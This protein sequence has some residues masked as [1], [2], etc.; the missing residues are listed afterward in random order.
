MLTPTPS[1]ADMGS[2]VSV[3]SFDSESWATL[4]FSQPGILSVSHP[5]GVNLS[6]PEL[7]GPRNSPC[8]P[9]LVLRARRGGGWGLTSSSLSGPLGRWSAR[10]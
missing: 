8:P 2:V 10:P 4:N 3:G 9:G 7:K 5:W 6:R 1:F